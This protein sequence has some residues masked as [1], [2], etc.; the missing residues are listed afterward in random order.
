MG[1]VDD[2]RRQR[3]A[4]HAQRERDAHRAP[5]KVADDPAEPPVEEATEAQPAAA[6]RPAMA[7]RAARRG[8]AEGEGACSACGK[9]RPLQNG[10]ISAHQKGLG[11]ICAG[12]R[13]PPR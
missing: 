11:K 3:E 7:G 10:V 5:T 12:S 2:M 6:T 4:Q 9:L 13:K 8:A 1:K